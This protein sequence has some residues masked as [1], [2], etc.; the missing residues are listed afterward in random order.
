[1]EPGPRMSRAPRASALCE[2]ARETSPETHLPTRV[3][4]GGSIGRCA[5]PSARAARRAPQTP[6]LG[7]A[8]QRCELARAIPRRCARKR[9]NGE[10]HLDIAKCGMALHLA[11]RTSFPRAESL[12]CLLVMAR[13]GAISPLVRP[14]RQFRDVDLGPVPSRPQSDTNP[15]AAPRIVA[16]DTANLKLPARPRP[17]FV[18]A[19]AACLLVE[20]DARRAVKRP[21]VNPAFLIIGQELGHEIGAFALETLPGVFSLFI[22]DPVKWRLCDHQAT[23]AAAVA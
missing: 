10:D 8:G 2:R 23:G 17:E 4:H 7:L 9:P 3:R 12:G 19:A 18:M 20:P 14:S 22:E 13:D 1:M 11:H 5:G 16:I 6:A 21:A 15:R